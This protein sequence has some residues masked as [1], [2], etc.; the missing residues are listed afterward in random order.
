MPPT[1][2]GAPTQLEKCTTSLIRYLEAPTHL[3]K[4]TTLRRGGTHPPKKKCTTFGRYTVELTGTKL[5]NRA[6]AAVA[7]GIA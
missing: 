3:E 1:S 7:R 4:Y 2:V 5:A 6:R